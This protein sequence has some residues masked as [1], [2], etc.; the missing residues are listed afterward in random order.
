MRQENES[1]MSFI[2]SLYSILF[3]NTETGTMVL[4]IGLFLGFEQ[5]GRKGGERGEKEGTKR[6][7]E[8]TEREGIDDMIY[9]GFSPGCGFAGSDCSRK[10]SNHPGFHLNIRTEIMIFIRVSYRILSQIEVF[11][12]WQ[13]HEH[14]IN[15]PIK[16]RRDMSK[17]R[18]FF[19][20]DS[21]DM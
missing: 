4:C 5:G 18:P 12:F 8:K 11:S 15:L 10:H 1:K 21:T 16:H 17:S 7:R 9:D 20:C 3:F 13:S 2:I 14:D 6:G 19:S